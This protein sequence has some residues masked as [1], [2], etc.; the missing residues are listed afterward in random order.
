[1]EPE[2]RV[3]NLAPAPLGAG[4]FACSIEQSRLIL[5]RKLRVAFSPVPQWL[6][7][8]DGGA[9]RSGFLSAQ[10]GVIEGNGGFD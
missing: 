3:L 8:A 9:V 10:D 7:F 5:R 1:V 6:S 4:V 2:L